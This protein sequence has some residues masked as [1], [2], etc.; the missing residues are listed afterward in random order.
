MPQDRNGTFFIDG[1]RV[2]NIYADMFG[3]VTDMTKGDMGLDIHVQYDGEN[4]S[5]VVM[6]ACLEVVGGG[7]KSA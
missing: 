7:I 2:H 4:Q 1:C 6:S 3:T 5:Q